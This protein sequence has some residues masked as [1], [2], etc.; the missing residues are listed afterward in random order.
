MLFGLPSS[1]TLRSSIPRESRHSRRPSSPSRATTL[2]FVEPLQVADD[3]EAEA[4]QPLPRRFADPPKP[5]D[6][7]RGEQGDCLAA[8]N[9]RKAFGF[10]EIGGELRQELA[11]A[12][13]D[14]D[15]HA[16]LA[17]DGGGEAS[18]RRRRRPPSAA[19]QPVGRGTPRRFGNS[20]SGTVLVFVQH[21]AHPSHNRVH[22][23]RIPSMLVISGVPRRPGQPATS[24]TPVRSIAQFHPADT[25]N[26]IRRIP[27]PLR[28]STVIPTRTS[29]TLQKQN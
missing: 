29:I 23:H 14:R 15:G 1:D 28:C 7:E 17:F 18:E 27:L 21:L 25:H 13:A 10:I 8:R 22:H 11:V 26:S 4:L 6:A 20:S 3:L 9:R 19:S 2:G 16:D 24:T 12:E 5:A